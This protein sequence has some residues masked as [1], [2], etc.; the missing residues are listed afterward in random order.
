M[1]HLIWVMVKK[2]DILIILEDL[3]I[4]IF[5]QFARDSDGSSS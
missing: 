3:G 2:K 5:N 4:Y 1:Y